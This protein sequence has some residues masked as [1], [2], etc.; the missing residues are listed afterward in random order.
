MVGMI[1]VPKC[2]ESRKKITRDYLFKKSFINNTE[3]GTYII[4]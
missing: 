1:S 3:L 2:E 4:I